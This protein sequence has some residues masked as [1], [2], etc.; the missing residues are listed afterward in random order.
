MT[1]G[2]PSEKIRVMIVEDE[3]LY[4]N[5]LMVALAENPLLEVVGSFGD[6][7]SALA[8]A[9]E[10]RPMVAVLDFELPGSMNGIQLGLLLRQQIPGIGIVLLSVHRHPRFLSSLPE[11]EA[12][13]WSYLLKTS[14]SDVDSLARAI[15]ASAAGLMV[16]DPQLM[17]GASARAGSRIS[18]LTDRQL[19]ILSLISQGL[20]NAAVAQRLT[21]AEKSVENQVN[22]IYQALGIDRDASSLQP[23]VKAVLIYLEET[24]RWGQDALFSTH[25]G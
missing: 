15:Q 16:L 24:Q 9:A 8:A 11:G 3:S 18:Q 4:R 2:E 22:L 19:E 1:T 21:L 20:T 14:V 6:G 17:K 10:L 12:A 13:G 7:E 25:G 23:R 5:L